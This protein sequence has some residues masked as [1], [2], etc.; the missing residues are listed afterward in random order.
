MEKLLKEL[1][2]ENSIR[3]ERLNSGKCSQY[4]HT[5][6]VNQYNVVVDIIKRI[7]S[8]LK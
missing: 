2:E 7:E 6:L 3:S 1:K 5:S 8:I 4:E